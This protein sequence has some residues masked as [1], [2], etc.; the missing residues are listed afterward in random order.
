MDF[1]VFLSRP[2]YSFD[3]ACFCIRIEGDFEELKK[4]AHSQE[5]GDRQSF[6]ESGLNGDWAAKD[7]EGYL[8]KVCWLSAADPQG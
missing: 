1:S 2:V 3:F 4:S 5:P 8:V 6:L 7:V